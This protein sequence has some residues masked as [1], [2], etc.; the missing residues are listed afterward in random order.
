LAD[1]VAGAERNSRGV[2]ER[3]KKLGLRGLE[4]GSHTSR[5]GDV[6]MDQTE[7]QLQKDH[8]VPKKKNYGFSQNLREKIQGKLQRTVSSP[9]S[10]SRSPKIGHRK[11]EIPL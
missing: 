9:N 8:L 11:T 3:G 1:K 7:I 5:S 6:P 10:S 2:G 4:R